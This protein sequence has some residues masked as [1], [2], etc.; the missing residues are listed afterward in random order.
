ML[1]KPHELGGLPSKEGNIL[2]STRVSHPVLKLHLG[3]WWLPKDQKR[4]CTLS[5][6][7]SMGLASGA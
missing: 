3:T 1:E 6:G 2:T 5:S 4:T 7:Y